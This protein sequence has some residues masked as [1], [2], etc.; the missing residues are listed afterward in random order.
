[1]NQKG[2]GDKILLIKFIRM[3]P[4]SDNVDDDGNNFIHHL[5]E[6]GDYDSIN[7]FLNR[8]LMEGFNDKVINLTNDSGETPLHLAVKN[9]FQDIA[10]LLIDFGADKD[11]KDK[12]GN[13]IKWVDEEKSKCNLIGGGNKK[14]ITIYGTRKL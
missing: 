9:N 5:V 1:M 7:E 12:N 13:I 11:I 2:G 14:K 3:M 4:V 8:Y 6:R 10:Q